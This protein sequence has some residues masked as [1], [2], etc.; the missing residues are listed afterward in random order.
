M[1]E[2]NIEGGG[3]GMDEWMREERCGS[4]FLSSSPKRQRSGGGGAWAACDAREDDT[5]A[6][7]TGC[8]R[9]DDTFADTPWISFPF[10]I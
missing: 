4:A 5:A 6:S 10:Y 3:R 9:E 8:Y 2:E 1:A 7:T